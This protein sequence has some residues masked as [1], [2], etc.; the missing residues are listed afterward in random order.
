MIKNSF[1]TIWFFF[2]PY[3]L[4]ILALFV[5]SVLVGGLE[6][7]NIAAVYPILSAAFDT[8][9]GEGNAILSTIQG[10]AGLLPIKDQFIAYCTVF[11]LIAIL[12]FTAKLAFIWFRVRFGARLVEKNQMEVLHKFMDA[13]YQYFVDHK[14]GELIY[15]VTSAPQFLATLITAVT[16]IMSQ[17]I[18][19]ISVLI[20]LLSLSWQG[21]LV[22]LLVGLVYYYLARYFG[23]KISYHSGK[24]EMKAL[25]EAAVILNEAF[26][27]IKQVKVFNTSQEW[28]SR[29]D[30][31]ME[32]RWHHFIRRNVS[33][34]V[35]SPFLMLIMYISIGIIAM[36]IKIVAPTSFMQ[37]I[38]VFGTFAFAVFR[39]F[40]IIASTGTNMMQIMGALP[41]CETVRSIRS[42]RLAYIEDGKKELSSFKANVQF[43][44]VTFTYKQRTRILEDVSIT[45]EKGKTT[46]IVGR[47]GVGKTTIINLLL[48]LFEPTKGE[49]KVDGVNLKEYKLSS[50][51]DKI[52]FVSQDTFI[53]N[54]TIRNNITFR[55]GNYSDEQIIRAAE[56]AAAH[57]FISELPEGYDTYVGDKGVKLSS[58]QG[59]RIAV[60]RAMIRE[61]EI[62]I[63]D[64][65]TNALD[66]ISEAAVQRAIDEISKDHTVIV[67]AHRLSTVVNADKIIVLGDGRLLEEGAHEE[68]LEKKGAYWQLYRSQPM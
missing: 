50:W 11:L 46:A 13:D 61:P 37:L 1:Q 17:V 36:L 67:I 33:Y 8:K 12:A 42:D 44:D 40:P 68:L 35:P 59:Q 14:Q 47:S 25:R 63:F 16:D 41:N 24:A 65:A 52:G 66:G 29:F 39:L 4:H 55:S 3:K 28:E 64:E 10:A 62:L 38:P 5:F 21:T 45:F 7:A 19:S 54:D 57:S 51:L 56:Y 27:G 58:G 30:D 22:V 31:S 15:N 2:K 48:R 6:A 60:A 18:L 26:S 20:L 43:A 32:R 53:F 34:Q 49:I 23:G 9:T